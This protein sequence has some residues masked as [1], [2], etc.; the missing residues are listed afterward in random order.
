MAERNRDEKIA[1]INASPLIFLAHAGQLAL[2]H[3]LERRIVVPDPV[4]EEISRRG[5]QDM[6]GA[7]TLVDE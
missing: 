3:L 2:L 4:M 1:V 7:L 5:S 6:N